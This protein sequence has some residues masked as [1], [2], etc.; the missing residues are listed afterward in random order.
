M[1][2]CLG[3]E[4]TYD[5]Q[6]DFNEE[7]KNF[8]HFIDFKKTDIDHLNANSCFM[9]FDVWMLTKS[10]NMMRHPVSTSVCFASFTAKITCIFMINSIIS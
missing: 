7:T 4:K 2:L 10:E 6:F 9:G 8:T 3:S 5:K 1:C